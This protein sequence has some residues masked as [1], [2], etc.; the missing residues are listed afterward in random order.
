MFMGKGE[1]QG[2]GEMIAAARN[3]RGTL[4]PWNSK[5][6]SMCEMRDCKKSAATT[7]SSEHGFFEEESG[8][9]KG[10]WLADRAIRRRST[11]EAKTGPRDTPLEIMEGGKTVGF[12]LINAEGV[13]T[14]SSDS[15]AGKRTSKSH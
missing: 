9:E 5:L 6:L 11:R 3:A 10:K 8:S 15:V 12:V 7:F 13:I 14:R 1:G 2:H 4:I